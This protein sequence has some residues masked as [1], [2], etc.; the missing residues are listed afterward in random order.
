MRS[1]KNVLYK[2]ISE[3]KIA[4]KDAMLIF[5]EIE[6]S[7]KYLDDDIAV[8]GMSGRLPKAGN[9]KE[10]WENLR[11]GINCISHIPES[12]REHIETILTEEEKNTVTYRP[13]GFMKNVDEFDASFFRISPKEAKFMEPEQRIFMEV[14]WEAIEDAGYSDMIYGTK[15]GVFVGH[16]HVSGSIYGRYTGGLLNADTLSLTG[17]YPSILSSRISYFLDLKGPSIVYDTACSSGLVAI[18]QA[19]Q[20]IKNLECDMVIAGGVSLQLWPAKF[21]SFKMIETDNEIVRT[22][23]K[24]SSGTVWGEGVCVFLL[25]PLS[26]ALEDRD[27]IHAVIKGSAI[28]N[29]GIS[30]GITAPNAKAQE[31]VIVKAWTEAKLEVETLSYIEAHGT[32][33]VMGDPIEIKALR[34]AFSQFTDK[35]QF[36]GI[37]SLKPNIGHLVS[38]SGTASLLK[39][40]LAMK[41]REIPATINFN[42]PNPYID[43]SESQ[44]YINDKLRKWEYEG[45]PRRSAVNCFGFSGTNCHMVLEEAPPKVK[46]Q[47]EEN[48]QPDLLVLSARSQGTLKN[49]IKRYC[50]YLDGNPGATLED[51]CYTASAGRRHYEHRIALVAGSIDE[52]KEKLNATGELTHQNL[53]SKGISYGVY[54]LVSR[55]T[56]EKTENELTQNEKVQLDM[57]ANRKIGEMLSNGEKHGQVLELVSAYYTK[58]AD[59]NWHEKLYKG[60]KPGKTSI[61]VYQFEKTKYWY[62]PE[63]FEKNIDSENRDC[64]F[65]TAWIN[66]ELHEIETAS[67]SA[68]VLV[69]ND[70][71]ELVSDL[72]KG[73]EG[74]G[75]GVVK[76]SLGTEFKR[77]GGNNFTI[78]L[79]E[80]DYAKLL[81]EIKNYNITQMLHLGTTGNKAEA[82]DLRTLEDLQDRGIF[83]L[84]YLVRGL[85]A[86]SYDNHIDLVLIS[87]YANQVDMS[88]AVINPHNTAFFGLAKVVS[89]E[90]DNL[91]TRCIDIDDSTSSETILKE[92]SAKHSD[93]LV[94]YRNGKRYT[95]ELRRFDLGMSEENTLE[96]KKKGAYLITGGTGG[97]GLE[98]GK[99]L[100]SENRV[101]LCLVNRTPIPGR[102]KWDGI[103]EDGSN[104]KLCGKLKAIR[105]IEKNGSKVRCYSADVSKEDEIKPVIEGI[106]AEFG[107]I[108]G[109][110]HCAGTA[111]D[112]FMERRFITRKN[113]ETFRSV[114]APKIKGTWLLDRLTEKDKPDIF[115]LASSIITLMGAQGQSDYC[116]ANSYLD[117][118]C[119]YRN[120][121]GGKT[122]TINWT[123]W[124]EVGMA[125]EQG[126]GKSSGMFKTITNKDAIYSLKELLNRDVKKAIIGELDFEALCHI[127]DSLRI[128]LSYEI[129]DLIERKTALL[130]KGNGL[131][132]RKKVSKISITG[133]SEG[134]PG[135]IEEAVGRIW[136]EVLEVEEINVQ[137]SFYD[138][139]GDSI[140]A[141]QL[142]KEIA[143]EY[144]GMVSISDIFDKPTIEEL[145]RLISKKNDEA[146]MEAKTSEDF[147]RKLKEMLDGLELGSETDESVLALLNGLRRE[148]DE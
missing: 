16:D 127:K 105:A 5:K 108:N 110:F 67:E 119:A 143:L 141:T 63:P 74:K 68:Y 91:R 116:T 125:A 50:E 52:M 128:N 43:F 48:Q 76:V 37:G 44:L 29:D 137:D 72:I 13:T 49:I 114:I 97:I 58:G 107:R 133:R 140:L 57:E 80:K 77:L 142:V 83:S 134:Q 148:N 42:E 122:V 15:T 81:A 70:D 82:R 131:E 17:T 6:N 129:R 11:N 84:F 8:I 103:L 85:A 78:G 32:G 4:P 45:H 138:M 111:G 123:G 98:I 55:H 54:K 47:T 23:D 20:A 130:S 7:T 139:G 19:C 40:I 9:L 34:N 53:G 115:V 101:N 18:H 62:L 51:I 22:F 56:S 69:F 3:Q 104:E 12:R 118:Y 24:D 95:D 120:K 61:P 41:H 99:H 106:R 117:S 145:A 28:N 147:D 60:R 136:A 14:A 92:L 2:L 93:N 100:A 65:E 31:D 109:V 88:E 35:R 86:N 102:E 1:V 113:E 144:P 26:K 135:V 90:F 21:N 132:S 79:C 33:T 36:C 112:G 38:A 46:K 27:N 124:K 75:K 121:K 71:S 126:L 39:V 66:K 94:A 64:Y 89:L 59:I 25:K 146:A 10:Y 30:S 87:D 96:I 73:L